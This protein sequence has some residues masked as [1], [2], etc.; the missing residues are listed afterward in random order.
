MPLALEKQTL[1]MKTGWAAWSVGVTA[2]GPRESGHSHCS[3]TGLFHFLPACFTKRS[4]PGPRGTGTV[5]TG[6]SPQRHQPPICS[7][8]G[9]RSLPSRTQSLREVTQEAGTELRASE[10]HIQTIPLGNDIEKRHDT[11]SLCLQYQ[12][13]RPLQGPPPRRPGAT[14]LLSDAM[15]RVRPCLVLELPRE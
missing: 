12:V 10:F 8:P 11:V 7:P 4:A 15:A 2:W 1:I 3:H 14:P 6:C 9:V 5:P 13:L